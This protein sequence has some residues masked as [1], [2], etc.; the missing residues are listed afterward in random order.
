[1][2]AQSKTLHEA[3]EEAKLDKKEKYEAIKRLEKYSMFN[4]Q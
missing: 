2:I 4:S 1:M 3:V